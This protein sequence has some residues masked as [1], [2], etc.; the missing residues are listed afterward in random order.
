V[1]L[2]FQERRWADAETEFH[3]ALEL[4]PNYATGHHWYAFFLQTLGRYDEAM[5]ERRRA[6]EIDPLTPMP[7]VGLSGL[8]WAM[9]QPD[10]ALEALK[11]TLERDPRRGQALAELGR[12]QEALEEFLEAERAAPDSLM[13]RASV[14]DGLVATGNLRDAR[15]RVAEAELLARST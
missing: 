1:A 15:R 14:V 9:R 8:Y 3:R 4:D 6:I 10:R 5:D 12:H 2:G 11:R 7:S 13:V